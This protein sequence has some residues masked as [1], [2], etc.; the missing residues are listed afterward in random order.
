MRTDL[1]RDRFE[2]ATDLFYIAVEKGSG[3]ISH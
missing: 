3:T 2:A 1:T